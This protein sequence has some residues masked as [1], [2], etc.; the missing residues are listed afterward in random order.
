V[1]ATGRFFGWWL[2]PT[3]RYRR[4]TAIL[5]IVVVVALYGASL[6]LARWLSTWSWP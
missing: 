3:G 4:R 1:P 5:G 6:L 2:Y